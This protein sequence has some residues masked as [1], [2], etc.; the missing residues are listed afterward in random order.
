MKSAGCRS[1]NGLVCYLSRPRAHFQILLV[2]GGHEK[3]CGARQDVGKYVSFSLSVNQQL[4]SVL[5]NFFRIS[6][7]WTGL[8][9]RMGPTIYARTMVAVDI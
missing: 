5:N 2:L 7:W 9:K 1:L 6:Y 8:L 4:I 3:N